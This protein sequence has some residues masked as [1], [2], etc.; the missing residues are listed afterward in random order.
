MTL[1]GWDLLSN[2]DATAFSQKILKPIARTEAAVSYVDHLPKNATEAAGAIGAQA[3]RAMTTGC[4]IKVEV[5]RVFGVGQR[6]ELRLS[7][8][9]DRSGI[10]RGYCPIGTSALGIAH[11]ASNADGTVVSIHIEPATRVPVRGTDPALHPVMEAISQFLERMDGPMSAAAI[12]RGVRGYATD[13]KRDAI[14]RLVIE[15]YVG[16]ER[17][18]QSLHHTHIRAFRTDPFGSDLPP[19]PTSPTSPEPRLAFP[20]EVAEGDLP[21]P[22]RS[23]SE[24]GSSGEVVRGIFEDLL[25]ETSPE[26]EPK[27]GEVEDPAVPSG[28]RYVGGGIA[29]NADGDFYRVDTGEQLTQ[30]QA[31]KEMDD[32]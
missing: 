5:E 3:K 25:E 24:R 7:V 10:V 12:E 8:D 29:M 16:Q 19:T 4:A 6:G 9:K 23:L 18:G 22:A 20:G 28:H 30:K 13:T 21:R 31:D 14:D 1:N 17:V 11:L 2:K 27:P 26:A 15:G 32:Q